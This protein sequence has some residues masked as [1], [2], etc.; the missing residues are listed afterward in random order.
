MIV[1]QT[2]ATKTI[3]NRIA[4]LVAQIR[5]VV[6]GANLGH[7]SLR[8]GRLPQVRVRSLDANLGGGG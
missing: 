4:S 3:V 5:V 1:M 8:E 2:D 7:P 6:L